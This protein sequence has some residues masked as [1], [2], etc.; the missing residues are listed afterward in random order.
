[1]IAGESKVGGKAMGLC[2]LHAANVR[3]P[4]WHVVPSKVFQDHFRE[5]LLRARFDELS[6]KI[7]E[8]DPDDPNNT[9]PFDEISAEIQEA[10][11]KQPLDEA[12]VSAL[13]DS[14][15]QLGAGPYAVRSS[16]AGEDSENLSFAGQLETYL[17]LHDIHQ[18][19]KAVNKCWA[20]AFSSRVLVYRRRAEQ[21]LSD[22]QMGV[23]VQKMVLGSVSGVLFTAD[24]VSGCRQTSV[25]TACWG[26]G[27]G[28]VSGACNTDQFTWS[29]TGHI[30]D[31]TI[32]DKD[33]KVVAHPDGS[34][35]TVET[36][37]KPETRN[38][39][40]L[41]DDQVELICSEGAR[42]ADCIGSPQ[43]I[44]WTLDDTGFFFLQSR[45]ITT[46]PTAPQQ[47]GPR[48]V[49][50]NSNIQESYC[51]VTTPLTFSF[52]SRAYAS[53]YRQTMEV[54]K[55]P[56]KT[57]EAHRSMLDNLLG[58]IRGR[59][60]YNINNWYRGL[61]L[62]PSFGRN[63]ADMEK[64]MGLDVPVDFI[65]DEDLTLLDTLK[66]VP[67]LLRTLFRLKRLFSRLSKDVSRFKSDFESA[68]LRIDRAGL[69]TQPLHRLVDLIRQLRREML[70]NWHTPIIN[71]FFVMMSMG[72]LRRLVAKTGREE[73]DVL[74]NNLLSGE[75]G[76]ESTEPTRVLMGLAQLAREKPEACAVLKAGSPLQALEAVKSEFPEIIDRIDGYIEKYGD[77]CMGELKL[78]TI[79]LRE[80]PGFI[81]DVVRNFLD[82][83]DLDPN[84]LA[85]KEKH[86]RDNAER[87]LRSEL[88]LIA[89]LSLS[90]VLSAARESVKNR[91]NMR[92]ARTRMFGLFRDVY[93]AIGAQ[94]ERVGRLKTERD[95]F[96]LTT[97]EIEAYCDGRAV[98]ADLKG[99]AET[100]KAEWAVYEKQD[101]PHHFE[102]LGAV[103]HNNEYR[104]P[105]Q[106]TITGDETELKGRPCYPGVVSSTARVILNPKDDLSVNG[107]ILVTVRTDPGWAPLFPT[108]SGILVE[109]GSTLSHSAVLARELGIPAI[110]GIPGL[111]DIVRDGDGL[112]MD[113]ETGVIEKLE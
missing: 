77:R 56:K 85:K 102:T 3:V 87:E 69:P 36:D 111:L 37:T 35:G 94:L 104:S 66:R 12:V 43:D 7:S 107:K 60:Y 22:V 88:G 61:L 113:G 65:E 45:P 51:G 31:A 112:R 86:L 82:R 34:A 25:L 90:R 13:Q 55:I 16:M 108:A 78:E 110:V 26:L 93:R 40:C 20:S 17:F 15:Q 96:Y 28:V 100:R 63:K 44:E 21:P 62:L 4:P 64:M 71:D 9:K 19:A 2:R 57:I 29:A 58:L 10:I 11:E 99:I 8:L 103:Y 38:Q 72:R 101:L 47:R 97:D 76:I 41:S 39:P 33:R 89:R 105:H 52:A 6:G 84:E 80:D 75:E 5:A 50:D 92:L 81:I 42:I 14:L 53:V 109:R 91:E 95:V 54:L 83:P 106:T 68:Y 18:V 79:S 46:L 27:E 30:L 23:L 24:P 73:G 98:S 32:A 49:W 59:I 48:V 70:E 74:I 1:M 67:R